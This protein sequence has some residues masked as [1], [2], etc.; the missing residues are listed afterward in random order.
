M[1]EL[2]NSTAEVL[3]IIFH[4]LTLHRAFA[5]N[6]QKMATFSSLKLKKQGKFLCSPFTYLTV[7]QSVWKV[8]LW[9]PGKSLLVMWYA[10]ISWA[11][12]HTETY[13]YLA[14]PLTLCPVE[15]KKKPSP[16]LLPISRGLM[17]PQSPLTPECC[18]LRSH[19]YSMPHR[20]QYESSLFNFHRLPTHI[21]PS[22]V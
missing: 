7:N 18:F 11:F 22:Q 16:R 12:W 4:W 17:F 20:Q 6:I 10:D 5:V 9:V 3:T 14:Q 19:F 13:L 15:K 8:T 1:W 21:K 2:V